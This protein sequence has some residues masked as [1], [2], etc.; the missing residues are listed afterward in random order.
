MIFYI[1]TDS[2]GMR[3]L[4]TTQADAK[5]ID[6]NFQQLDVPTDKAGLRDAIQELLTE[7][8]GMAVSSHQEPVESN[9]APV[10]VQPTPQ[11]LSPAKQALETREQFDT[12]W[13]SF[14][15]ALKLHYAASACED[16]RIAIKPGD[17][18]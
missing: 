11:E 18:T 16:A 12:A 15:L 17:R 5:A 13:G 7:I 8:D 10:S 6:K 3:Q 14:P 4:C 9:P 1:A 2:N